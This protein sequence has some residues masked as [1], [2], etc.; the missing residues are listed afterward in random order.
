LPTWILNMAAMEGPPPPPPRAASSLQAT[1][2][3]ARCVREW[4]GHGA[5]ELHVSA[6][7]LLSLLPWPRDVPAREGW[8]YGRLGATEGCV[9]ASHGTVLPTHTIWCMPA[10][11]V[12]LYVS[13]CVC[14]RS[15]VR[16]LSS[17]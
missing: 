9:P 1:L 15:S 13:V 16:R 17:V 14:V 7:D 4:D 2:G 3:L 11:L 12:C 10:C 6:G 8:V 5:G